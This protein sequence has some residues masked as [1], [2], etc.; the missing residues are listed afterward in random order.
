MN[1]LVVADR[2]SEWLRVL[3]FS[4]FTRACVIGFREIRVC[5]QIG[6]VL[7]WLG[8]GLTIRSK[9]EREAGVCSNVKPSGG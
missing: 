4:R 9:L 7:Q 8:R 1:A 5:L 2:A 3:S 6:V